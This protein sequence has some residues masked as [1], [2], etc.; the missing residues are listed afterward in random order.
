MN[1]LKV[2]P[3]LEYSVAMSNFIQEKTKI[4]MESYPARDFDE[5]DF[6]AR[7]KYMI[8]KSRF[9]KPHQRRFKAEFKKANPVPVD[10]APQPEFSGKGFSPADIIKKEILGQLGDVPVGPEVDLWAINPIAVL[11]D[12]KRD[13][14]ANTFLYD[15]VSDGTGKW[16]IQYNLSPSEVHRYIDIVD[17]EWVVYTDCIEANF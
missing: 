17:G 5:S 14:V 13:M 3:A 16:L 11:N 2:S 8:A 6:Q 15:I 1:R 9:I 4:L 7:K 12:G 10:M